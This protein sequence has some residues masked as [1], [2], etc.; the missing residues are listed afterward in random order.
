[1]AAL[2]LPD[3]ANQVASAEQE[4]EWRTEVLR[5]LSKG[6]IEFTEAMRLLQK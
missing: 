3:A 1:V 6:E 5:R 4:K 2:N